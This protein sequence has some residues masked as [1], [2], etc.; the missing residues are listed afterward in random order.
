MKPIG[1]IPPDFE[2]DGQ[3][4]LLIGG[5]SADILV[6]EAGGT[7]LIVYDSQIISDRIARFRA[8][9]PQEVSLHYAV[10][11][12]PYGPLLEFLAQHPDCYFQVFTNGQLIT[13]DVAAELRRVGNVSPLISVEGT[14]IVSDERRG[15]RRTGIK[16]PFPYGDERFGIPKRPDLQFEI[17]EKPLPEPVRN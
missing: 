2:A 8:A 5:R 14:E 7:P 9:M 1:P 11:A 12:N 4:R 15:Y 10:K 17:L 13:D 6:E 16:K 3:G